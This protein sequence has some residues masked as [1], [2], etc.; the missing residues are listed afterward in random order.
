MSDKPPTDPSL[1][2]ELFNVARE[3]DWPRALH[4]L[5]RFARQVRGDSAEHIASDDA[6]A[7]TNASRLHKAME[8]LGRA[9]MGCVA[10]NPCNCPFCREETEKP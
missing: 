6:S 1:A 2:R 7:D 8:T 9:S 5:G 10:P 4:R 3:I